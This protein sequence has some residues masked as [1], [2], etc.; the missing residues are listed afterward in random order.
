L[1]DESSGIILKVSTKERRKNMK[2]KLT[3][4]EVEAQVYYELYNYNI[5]R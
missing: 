5:E 4:A 1:T 2:K 3:K